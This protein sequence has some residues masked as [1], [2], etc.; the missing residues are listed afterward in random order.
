MAFLTRIHILF[1]VIISPNSRVYPCTV[2]I[3]SKEI[4]SLKLGHLGA[5]I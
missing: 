5:S 4:R 3:P 2:D 1:Y